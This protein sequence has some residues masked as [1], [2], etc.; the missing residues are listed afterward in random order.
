MSIARALLWLFVLCVPLDVWPVPGVGSIALAVGAPLAV[1]SVVALLRRGSLRRMTASHLFMTAFVLWSA[2]SFFWS[3]DQ[4]AT[5]ARVLTNLGLLF[6]A[7]TYR[8]LA[9]RERDQDSLM[10][11]YVAGCA[12]ASA[13]TVVNF[14]RGET[15]FVYETRYV[16]SG[17]DPN[18]LGVTL[19][20]G[21][22]LAWYLVNAQRGWKRVACLIYVPLAI[23]A[24][25]LTASRGALITAA[26]ASLIIPAAGRLGRLRR[27]ALAVVAFGCAGYAA[28]KIV[29]EGAWT[30]LLTF[31]EQVQTGSLNGRF[32]IWKEGLNQLSHSP[33]TGVGAGAL[34][35]SVETV[36]HERVPAHN[37]FVSVLVELGPLGLILFVGILLVAIRPA[38]RAR[39]ILVAVLCATW[40][41]GVCSLTWEYRKTTWLVFSLVAGIAAVEQEQRASLRSGSGRASRQREALGKAS[42]IP[43][44]GPR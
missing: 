37:A 21:I 40:T 19:A 4:E 14:L 43:Q 3:V 44:A 1:V 35:S 23:V 33:F 10:L 30:R 34:P 8:Q 2:L 39:P 7:W 5:Q 16:A 27:I 9:D 25:F 18:D 12:I 6:F 28:V 15:T 29:P 31:G 26:T 42:T 22:P 38:L 13:A 11:A 36:L 32:D 17:Y 24:I 20:L 41:V